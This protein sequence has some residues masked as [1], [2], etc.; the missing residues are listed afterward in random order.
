MTDRENKQ[1]TCS[2]TYQSTYKAAQQT[3]KK[4]QIVVDCVPIYIQILI[5]TGCSDHVNN[6]KY[7]SLKLQ[8]F[9]DRTASKFFGTIP[10][11]AKYLLEA[12]R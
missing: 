1:A 12:T 9:K 6:I 5:D 10:K 11:L 4:Q 3:N 8:R 7:Q 2:S